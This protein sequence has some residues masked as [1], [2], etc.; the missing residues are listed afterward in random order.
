MAKVRATVWAALQ[1]EWLMRHH[2]KGIVLFKMLMT[3]TVGLNPHQ[4]Q[5]LHFC[6]SARNF[7]RNKQQEFA[8]WNIR[9]VQNTMKLYAFMFDDERKIFIDIS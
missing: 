4:C 1:K 7:A 8:S 2:V 3:S 6:L 9:P 5:K